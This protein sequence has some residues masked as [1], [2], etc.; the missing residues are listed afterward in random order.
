[1]IANQYGWGNWVQDSLWV[2]RGWVV[3]VF[4]QWDCRKLGGPSI[5]KSKDHWY[6]SELWSPAIC[7]SS[8]WY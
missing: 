8:S 6:V 5:K 4:L 1:M 3:W 2:G 7:C